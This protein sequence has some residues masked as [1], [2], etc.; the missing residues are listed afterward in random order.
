VAQDRP[1]GVNGMI[2]DG[3][4]VWVADLF[5]HQLIRFDPTTG[6]ISERYGPDAGLCGTDDVVVLA[7]GDLVA[8][9]PTE[10]LVIRVTRGRAARVLASVGTGVNP[11]AL[12][13]SGTS[14]VVGWGNSSDDRLLRIGVDDGSVSVLATGLPTLNGFD[15]GPDGYLY[16]PT[17]GAGGILGTGG[18]ARIDLSTGAFTQ[19]PLTFPGEPDKTGFD[20]A[21]GVDVAADGTVFVGQC[22]DAAAY[23]VDP[24]TGIATLVGRSPLGL[25][26]NVLV[27]DDGRVLLS[28]FFGGQVAVF[29]P[30]SSGY[31]TSV[32]TVG[33]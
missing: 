22:F 10:G 27:R 21:C 16:A 1:F 15:I 18:L 28:G 33:S 13:P 19:L 9:C 17:G 23:A 30:S 25:S 7:D 2:Q 4:D 11:I 3:P 29:T 5:G 31:D 20:F 24:T 6:A 26:D 12:E 14:V 32:V 8:T